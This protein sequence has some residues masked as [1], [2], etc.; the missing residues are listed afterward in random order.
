[1]ALKKHQRLRSARTISAVYAR[2]RPRHHGGLSIRVHSGNA[3][4]T[5]FAVIVPSGTVSQAAKRNRIRRRVLEAL[6][7]LIQ[8]QK[9]ADG[10]QVIITVQK[11]TFQTGEIRETLVLL[12]AKSG[13]LNL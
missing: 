10:M 3:G 12:L 1:M 13:I 11:S 5:R 9:L 2:I 6:R 7:L 4:I 8:R